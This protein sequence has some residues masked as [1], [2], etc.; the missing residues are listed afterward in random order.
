[1][2]D[3]FVGSWRE[4][5]VYVRFEVVDAD[6]DVIVVFVEAVDADDGGVGYIRVNVP[7]VSEHL[8]A[9]HNFDYFVKRKCFNQFWNLRHVIE[10]L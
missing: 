7:G 6:A 8:V 5:E 4:F 1:V 3:L 2:E 9:F 10:I